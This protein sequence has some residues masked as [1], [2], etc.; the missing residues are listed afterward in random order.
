MKELHPETP[1]IPGWKEAEE[2]IAELSS[3]REHL[4]VS[5]SLDDNLKLITDALVT[6]FGADFARIWITKDADLCEKGCIH[7]SV[8]RGPEICRDRTVCLHLV[9]SSGRYTHIDGG[10]RRVPMGASKIG[11]V[12]T[13]ENPG[14]ITNDLANDLRVHDHEW[15]QSLGLVSFAGFRLISPDGKPVGVLALFRKRAINPR[16]GKYLEDLAGT[17]SLV[18]QTGKAEA[19]LRENEARFREIFNNSNDAVYLVSLKEDGSSGNFILVNQRAMD[20]LGYS[21]NEFLGMTPADLHDPA[22]LPD[23]KRVEKTLSGNRRLLT[24][25]THRAKDGRLIPVELSIHRFGLGEKG[26][27]LIVARDITDRNQAEEA[28]KRSERRLMDIID[29]LPDATLVI[30]RGGKVIMWNKAIEQMTGVKADEMLG[31]GDHEYALPFYGCRRLLL[32]DLIFESDEEIEKNYQFMQK[33]GDLL[34]AES[35]LPKPLGK[36]GTLWGKATPLYDDKGNKIGA[37]ESIDRKSVV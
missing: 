30:D 10:Y 29:H 20:M 22:T 28:L 14:C 8:T 16:E 25:T 27:N 17:T 36:V 26:A 9:A 21:E 3:L 6:I 18:I 11:R 19:V 37:I 24:E 23:V 31:K 7:A 33:E 4:L 12:A 32:A 15:A 1:D 2:Y 35:D 5:R 34:V 13:G